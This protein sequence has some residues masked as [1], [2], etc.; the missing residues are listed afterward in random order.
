MRRQGTSDL[1]DPC[2]G[3]RWLS[4]LMLAVIAAASARAQFVFNETFSHSTFDQ[5][6]WVVA[7]SNGTYVPT[8]TGGSIDANGAGWLRMTNNVGQQATYARLTTPI[9][10]ASNNISVDMRFQMWT[11]NGQGADGFTI[12]LRDASVTNFD[13]GAFGGSLGYAQKNAAAPGGA[14]TTHAGMAGGYFSVGVDAYGNFSNATEGRQGG[15]GATPNAVSVRGPGSGAGTDY[16]GGTNNNYAYIDGTT[17]LS[18]APYSLGAVNFTGANSRPVDSNALNER[19]L[20]FNFTT[21][22]ILTVSMRFGAAGT[23]TQVFQSDLTNL[24]VRPENLELVFTA[25]TGGVMQYTEIKG[26]SITTSG[27]PVGTIFYSNYAGD[28]KCGN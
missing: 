27:A 7:S 23:L 12:S 1:E 18:A 24:G 11:P 21:D 4:V 10:S 2:D 17:N 5:S 13:V 9:P 19:E 8:L 3:I 28:N 14:D 26:L 15:I 25:G 20:V 22:N 6:G 16:N